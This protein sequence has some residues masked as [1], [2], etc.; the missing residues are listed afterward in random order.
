MIVRKMRANEL[1]KVAEVQSVAFEFGEDVEKAKAEQ[2]AMSPEEVAQKENVTPPENPFPAEYFKREVWAAMSD[3][4]KTVYGGLEVPP[5]TVR[6]DGHLCVMGGIGGVATL[7]PYRRNGAIRECMRSALADMNE[8]G[9]DFSYL[10]PFSRAYYRKFGYEN[11]YEC[12]EWEVDFKALRN[13]GTNGSVK[14]L[15][16]G[17]DF[18]VLNELYN[19]RYADY[20]LSSVRREYDPALTKKNFLVD[21]EF[22]YVWYNEGGEPKGF[23][24]FHNSDGVIDCTPAFGKKAA[25]LALDME[26]YMGLFDFARTFAPNYHAIRFCESAEIHLD[27]LL[28]ENNEVKCRVYTPGM[29]RV[30]SVQRVLE[31]CRCKGAG[32]LNIQVEDPMAP[33]NSGTWKLKY[34]QGNLV[35]KTEDPADVKMTINAF[36]S[37]IL[38][39]IDFSDV[40][41]VPGVTV[42]RQEAPFA[43]VFYKKKSIVLDLF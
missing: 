14:M 15:M 18:T 21:K 11:G 17:D 39:H 28:H 25:F 3:D 37:L 33:W 5:Y 10:Y 2:E 9:Y 23:M 34:G 20:G 30:V 4:E 22:A 24:I 26:A 12:R 40:P 41:F 42:L 27:A 19:K 31:K 43:D 6:F 7:P 29:S 32:E 35:E 16:A 1:Y 36:S 13:Y 8:K 38:G